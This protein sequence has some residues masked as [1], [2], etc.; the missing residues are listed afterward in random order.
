MS[1]CLFCKIVRGDIPAKIAWSDDRVVAFHDINPQAPVHLLVIPK[2]HIASVSAIAP[3]DEALVGH[4]V[5]VAG[6]LAREFGIEAGG[7]RTVLN[8]GAEAGQTVFHLHLHLVGGRP[9]G[10]PP[11]PA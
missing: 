2:K 1:D 6:D 10:W 11:F 9:M 3:E 4:V 8:T 5:R 7:Y